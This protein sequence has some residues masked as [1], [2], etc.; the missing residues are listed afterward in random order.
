MAETVTYIKGADLPDLTI[1]W[2]DGNGNLIDFSS[3][4][5]FAALIGQNGQSADFAKT[6]G[7]TGAAT[8]P[9]LTIAWA[10]TGELNS[11]DARKSYQVAITATRTADSKE[12]K[13]TVSVFIADTVAAV[14]P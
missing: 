9:N 10:V 8:D 5:T 4:W 1:T 14:A 12:R 7:F 3:G 11:L 2:K 13:M 6:T